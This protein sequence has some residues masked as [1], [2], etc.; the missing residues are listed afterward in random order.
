M[1]YYQFQCDSCGVERVHNT[2]CMRH[3]DCG[4]CGM[5]A[6]RRVR[7]G[8]EKRKTNGKRNSKNS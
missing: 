6:L 3:M 8:K 2:K 5:R 7:A 4:K 1:G